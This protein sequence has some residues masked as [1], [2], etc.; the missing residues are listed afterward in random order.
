MNLIQMTII[1]ATVGKN[2]LEE[3]EYPS[4]STKKSEMQYL[5]TMSKTKE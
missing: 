4:Q 3:M 5:E 1:C 2:A